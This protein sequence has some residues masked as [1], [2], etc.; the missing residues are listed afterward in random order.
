MLAFLSL[1]MLTTVTLA[2]TTR[3]AYT[4]DATTTD[5]RINHLVTVYEGG[6]VTIN[7][8]VTLSRKTNQQPPVLDSF[9]LGFPN[10]FRISISKVWAYEGQNPQQNLDVELDTGLGVEGF[11]GVRVHFK[12]QINLNEVDSYSFTVVYEFSDLIFENVGVSDEPSFSLVFPVYPSLTFEASSCNSTVVFPSSVHYT[13]GSHPFNLTTPSTLTLIEEPLAAFALENGGM[14]FTADATFNLLD[15]TEVNRKVALN[16]LN[17]IEISDFYAA[18]SRTVE[19]ITTIP[20]LLPANAS[21]II[22][23]DDIGNKLTVTYVAGP[24]NSVMATITL[25]A[26]IQQ[27][28]TAY[29]QVSY[30]LPWK[31]YVIRDSWD[32]YSFRFKLFQPMNMTVRKVTVTVNLPEG[33]EFQSTSSTV[34]LNLIQS[35]IYGKTPVFT[36]SNISSNQDLNVEV[37]FKHVVFWSSFRP[38]LWVGALV[39]IVGIVAF[40]WQARRVAEPTTVAVSTVLPIRPEELRSYVRTYEEQSKLQR[41]RESLETQARKG[42]IPR[43]L[44]KVRSRTLESRLSLLSRDM[45]VLRDKIRSAGPRYSDMMRQIEIAQTELQTVEADIRRTE[46]RYRRSEISAVAYHKLLEDYL[47]RKD[48]AQTNID[49][50]LLRLRE[51]SG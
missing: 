12:S 35:G 38:T 6:F 14:Y 25:K 41:E 22:A 42:R 39:A 13:G 47:K 33:S 49:G 43:R 3:A 44:Y 19:E 48:R 23:E 18:T 2:I 11:Y 40:L 29:I 21:N 37:G 15:I 16:D 7:D 46:A 4:Q 27:Y 50:I 31:D 28:Q 17:Q 36:V 8:K 26:P 51:E 34:Q 24:Q 1:I 30:D 45:A 10:D 5:V 20:T 9:Q 32:N